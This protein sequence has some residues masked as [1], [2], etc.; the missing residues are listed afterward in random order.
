MTIPGDVRAKQSEAATLGQAGG[1]AAI[2]G[3]ITHDIRPSEAVSPIYVTARSGARKWTS[4]ARST[5]TYWMRHGAL[6]SALHPA[7]VT[8]VQAQVRAARISGLATHG[9]PLGRA[10]EPPRAVRRA[11][12]AHDVRDRATDLA[13]RIARA[14]H[15]SPAHPE[16]HGPLPRLAR[17]C[18]DRRQSSVR[19]PAVLRRAGRDAR[20]GHHV[21][22]QR[23][24]GGRD[25]PGAWRHRGRH[26]RAG[27]RPS[28][29]RRRPFPAIF[30]S[31]ARRRSATACCSSSTRSSPGFRYAPGGAPG[32][33]RRDA[34]HHDARARIV[35]GGLPGGAVCGRR[36]VMSM[37]AHRGDPNWT[38]ASAWPTR[39]RSTPTR[40]RR[41]R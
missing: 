10:G 13:L 38:A 3:G 5:S 20:P 24:Q 9:S 16:I 32:I 19:R 28:R 2:P 39:G 14:F 29:A 33:L 34:G 30:R 41:R 6:F 11:D 15:R 27:R 12:R 35:A 18:R 17:R 1:R 21:P 25:D 22:A 37:L 31:C 7:V 23:H 26:H 8:A 40:C 36:D 4:T